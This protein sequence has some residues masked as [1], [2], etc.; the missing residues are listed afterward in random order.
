M[1]QLQVEDWWRLKIAEVDISEKADKYIL[2]DHDGFNLMRC[3]S[4]AV[5]S[6]SSRGSGFGTDEGL[7]CLGTV[8]RASGW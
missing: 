7:R 2:A 4:S 5:S 3:T 1:L 6:H 8:G